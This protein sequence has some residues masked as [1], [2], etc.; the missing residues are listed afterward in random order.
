MAPDLIHDPKKNS[1]L[2]TALSKTSAAHVVAAGVF[3]SSASWSPSIHSHPQRLLSIKSHLTSV[4]ATCRIR[5]TPLSVVRKITLFQLPAALF[6]TFC[7]WNSAPPLSIALLTAFDHVDTRFTPLTC[8]V[9]IIL[10]VRMV[11]CRHSGG[12]CRA[13]T[14]WVSARS[15]RVS[16]QCAVTLTMKVRALGSTLSLTHSMIVF[17]M[18]AFASPASVVRGPLPIHLDTLCV[19]RVVSLSHKYSFNVDLRWCSL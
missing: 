16:P 9:Y 7:L 2:S 8:H 6:S 14:A 11:H 15:F 3:L 1:L 10:G 17:M 19:S 18:S 5:A 4:H 12:N 13:L